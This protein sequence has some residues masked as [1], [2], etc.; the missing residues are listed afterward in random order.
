MEAARPAWPKVPDIRRDELVP[1]A[2]L[3][4]ASAEAIVD[5]VSRYRP[6]AL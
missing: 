1:P 3:E 2:E 4:D 6:I 5:A